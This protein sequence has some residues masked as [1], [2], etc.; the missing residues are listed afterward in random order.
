[1]LLKSLRLR[2][3]RNYEK[4]D[5]DFTP[6]FHL[7]LGRNGQGK[8]NLLEAI[9]L[10]ATLRSFRGVPN[11]QVVRRGAKGFFVGGGVV[12][13]GEHSVRMYWSQ[14][15]RKITLDDRPVRKLS[16]FMGVVRAVAFCSEDIHLIKG[17]GRARRRF[18]DLVL[19]QVEPG[20]MRALRR[21]SHA[22][23]SRNALLKHGVIDYKALDGFTSELLYWGK[24]LMRWRN[25]LVPWLQP[26]A[27]KAYSHISGGL[28][29]L[30]VEYAPSAKTDFEV[31]LR[32]AAARESRYKTTV[33]GPHRDDLRLFLDDKPAAQFGSE[34]QKRTLAVA[35][36]MAQAECL[37]ERHGV[38]PLLLI[39]DVMGEL[40]AQRRRGLVPLLERTRSSNG[41][42]F[43]TSTE[44]NWPREL[45]SAVQVWEVAKG[46]L[47]GLGKD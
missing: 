28:E 13:V 21:Y 36:K 5:V 20:Y 27:S 38:V 35:L 26:I 34:G 14:K 2:D 45:S 18:M 6:G 3:F 19:S 25:G 11:G 1:M 9:Y 32:Q 40:D 15:D 4:L 23:R 39:D 30:S 7:V 29:E 46:V 8:T 10:L 41:Q 17:P 43:M 24:Q 16:E 37:I 44:A 42:V 31:E 22:L 12:G 33:V 47:G